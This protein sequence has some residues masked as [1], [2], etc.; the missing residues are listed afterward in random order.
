[1]KSHKIQ[2]LEFVSDKIEGR[3]KKRKAVR[4]HF[5]CP[6]KRNKLGWDFPWEAA[7]AALQTPWPAMGELAGEGTE[8][9]GDGRGEG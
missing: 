5:S 6:T 2:R 9:K 7:M 3:D 1:M 8:G 4:I